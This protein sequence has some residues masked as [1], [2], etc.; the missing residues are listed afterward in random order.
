MRNLI[1]MDRLYKST[2]LHS[3]R[4]HYNSQNILAHNSPRNDSLFLCHLQLTKWNEE[5]AVPQRLLKKRL[6]LP[7]NRI[8]GHPNVGSGEILSCRYEWLVKWCGLDYEYA[9]WELENASFFGTF[10]G[11]NLLVEYEHRQE[12]AKQ[13][14]NFVD[15]VLLIVLSN[16]Y[17]CYYIMT[18]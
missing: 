3:T 6:L 15:K 17:F 8:N 9:T 7:T 5:W 18:I 1:E 13:A 14:A 10:C 2:L 16:S 12:K 4:L 11:Q